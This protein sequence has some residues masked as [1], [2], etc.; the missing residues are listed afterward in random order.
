MKC[1]INSN[2]PVSKIVSWVK[3]SNWDG[4]S[5]NE[6]LPEY[7]VISNAARICQVEPDNKVFPIAEP[8]FWVDCHN[9]VVTDQFY[10]NTATN[11]I[12]PIVNAPVPVFTQPEGNQ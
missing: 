7:A 9:N 8:L 12:L 1:L 4:K 10:F 6:Y 5:K 11:E 3:N 2:E